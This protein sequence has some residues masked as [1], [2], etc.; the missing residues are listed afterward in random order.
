MPFPFEFFYS[1]R[2]KAE[3]EDRRRKLEGKS[4]FLREISGEGK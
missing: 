1:A 4:R 3:E 2:K